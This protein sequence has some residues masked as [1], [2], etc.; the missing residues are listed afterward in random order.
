MQTQQQTLE[1]LE[2]KLA[3][4]AA[5]AQMAC[6]EWASYEMMD[7]RLHHLVA[8]SPYLSIHIYIIWSIH[9]YIIW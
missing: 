1:A 7:K 4:T 5:E 9:I 6:D 8:T 2:A 3:S